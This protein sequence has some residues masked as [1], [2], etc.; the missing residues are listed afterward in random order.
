MKRTKQSLESTWRSRFLRLLT[1]ALTAIA[2][3][4]LFEFQGSLFAQDEIALPEE[5]LIFPG[6]GGRGART[7]LT[8]DPIQAQRLDGKP[9]DVKAG[10]TVPSAGKRKWESIKRSGKNN[11]KHNQ[12]A[13]GY[14]RLSIPS[15][16]DQVAIL[17]VAGHLHTLINGE[18]RAGDPYGNGIV[19]LPILLRSGTNELLV[20]SRNREIN[21][22]LRRPSQ[23]FLFNSAD[24]TL[25]DLIEG[26]ATD[27]WAAVPVINATTIPASRL[28]IVATVDGGNPTTTS[29][30]T[31]G[32]LSTY[33]VPFL[34]SG[35]AVRAEKA[36]LKLQL[37]MD[38]PEGNR[39]VGNTQLT[40]RVRK[41]EQE[42]MK[43]FL[44]SIDT[45]VQYYS[46]VRAKPEKG[47]PTPGLTLT[48]HGAGVE[49]RGQAACYAPKSWTHVVAATNRRPFGFD[50][51]DW[52]RLDA[53]EVLATAERALKSDPT[54]RFLTGH[55]MGGHGTWHVGVAFPD[56][57]AAIG[58]SA[59]W[60]SMYSYAGMRRTENPD[61]IAAIMQRASLASDTL[62]LVHNIKSQ[63]VYVL[64][65]DKDDNVPV[66]L[67][68]TMK[69]VLEK[70]H[71]NMAYHEQK[72][73]GHWWGNDCVDWP[74]MFE[75]FRKHTLPERKTVTKVEFTTASPGVSAECHWARIESQIKFFEL[76]KIA[77]ETDAK[78]QRFH[79]TTTNVA[80]LSLDPSHLVEGS[81]IHVE[82]DGQKLSVPWSAARLWFARDGDR[83]TVSKRPSANQKAPHRYGPFKDAFRNGMIFVY[84][85]QGTPDEN[86]ATYAKARFDAET[87]WYRGNGA[88]KVVADTQF[89]SAATNDPNIILYGNADT[90]S[91]WAVLLKGSPVQVRRE[92]VTVGR[93]EIKGDDLVC[94]FVGPNANSETA[95]VAAVSATSARGMRAANRLPVFV[96]GIG[97]PDLFL[98]SASALTEGASRIRAAGFFGG[99]W[100]VEAGDFAW[101]D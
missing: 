29:I 45:S 83:W 91:A 36:Q 51:E 47:D 53:L 19:K 63:G 6:S 57:F 18:P 30:P 8:V 37:Q 44:S 64:H 12:L 96:S 60:I 92:G 5:G 59:G 28:T 100:S 26:E 27:T 69:G 23:G 84:G 74:P 32:P 54:R 17:E 99:D 90:N 2:I 9:I 70:F 42:H 15:E 11:W 49:G 21:V 3:I 98:Y 66:G 75:F 52:G 95:C 97:Y 13:G 85:T 14:L 94:L 16:K 58:P 86:A 4:G 55:S 68:R 24:P 71:T 77:I 72:D 78:Q 38:G 33:K 101:R 82:L 56:K 34:L 20:Q 50:W 39:V 1:A 65:G 80:R 48:L 7:A 62:S 25:P 73:A 46:V 88:V 87:F 81:T 76:S 41:P 40:L 35:G 67:A 61:A 22:S 31:L 43:T 79:G 10:D 89:K 93:R